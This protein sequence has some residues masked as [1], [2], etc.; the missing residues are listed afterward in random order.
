MT[1]ELLNNDRSAN[2]DGLLFQ[3]AMSVK[4]LSS[5][6]L[7]TCNS[8]TAHTVHEETTRFK[9]KLF[10]PYSKRNSLGFPTEILET[11]FILC[12]R[13]YHNEYHG[14]LTPTLPSWVNVSYVCR[15]WR[16]V[17]LNCPILW[18]YIFVAPP[19]W[20]G[21]LFA[22]SKQA[23][24]KLSMPLNSRWECPLYRQFPHFSEEL[25]INHERIQELHLQIP[26]TPGIRSRGD[27]GSDLHTPHLKILKISS[28]KNRSSFSTV[29]I[30]KKTLELLILQVLR[31]AVKWNSLTLSGLTTLSLCHIPFPF[32]ENT[33]KF[34]DSLRC[35][36]YLKHLYLDRALAS[37]SSFLSSAAFHTFRKI[38]LPHLSHL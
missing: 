8:A 14:H 6:S 1:G 38:D 30:H 3:L 7:P 5:P 16:N 25:T 24:L 11:I 23:P 10:N 21:E 17:A 12:A 18:A 9:S 4:P 15:H 28:Y 37:A 35:M 36:Q 20:T 19:R 22:R 32:Q 27:F 13:D 26:D 31:S 2:A 33:I 34:L 29:P